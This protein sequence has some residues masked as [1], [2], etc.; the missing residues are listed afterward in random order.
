MRIRKSEERGYF[1][2]GWLKTYHTF[3][4]GEY[5]DQEH[6][7]FS[8]LRVINHDF[9]EPAN[10][11]PLHGHRDMEIITY[12]L[13]GC[14]EHQDSMGNKTQIQAGEV[15]VMSAGSGVQH[16]EYNPSK[17]EVLE[18]VQIWITPRSKG[19]KPR[20]AQKSTAAQDRKDKF[21]QIVSGKEDSSGLLIQQDCEIYALQLTAGKV[22]DFARN[23]LKQYWIQVVQ[24]E[25]L[26]ETTLGKNLCKKGDALSFD[27]QD[28]AARFYFSTQN[29][30]EILLF[31]LQ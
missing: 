21:L 15:Q 1:D 14:V 16:S 8:D 11:F 30:A 6:M 12:V 13:K 18:L 3:S 2:F 25:L 24:G 7:H 19:G 9:I 20:Y 17:S 27:K 23:T 28:Q 4:F 22:I 26:I 10:G 31:E 5:F 29:A